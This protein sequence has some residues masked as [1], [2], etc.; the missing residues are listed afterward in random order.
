MQGSFN[1]KNSRE[2]R[3]RDP[4]LTPG[5]QI[6]AI[7]VPMTNDVI[8]AKIEH[9][10]ATPMD[11]GTRDHEAA[12]SCPFILSLEDQEREAWLMFLQ[13]II[14]KEIGECL[15]LRKDEVSRLLAAVR[16]KIR[17]LHRFWVRV[18]ENQEILARFGVTLREKN[19]GK[20]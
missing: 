12:H 8:D 17:H 1:G 20:K 4:S 19:G 16:S 11:P 15:C 3:R 13:G 14:A 7:T 6:N 9:G 10:Q 2:A 5:R 18:R